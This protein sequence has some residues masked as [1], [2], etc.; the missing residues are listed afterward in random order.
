[1]KK[2]IIEYLSVSNEK[3]IL[4]FIERMISETKNEKVLD[5]YY[6]IKKEMEKGYADKTP[7]EIWI[8]EGMGG[9]IFPL[10]MF[11][12]HN[13]FYYQVRHWITSQ[14]DDHDFLRVVVPMFILENNYKKSQK[15]KFHHPS[16]EYKSFLNKRKEYIKRIENY[17]I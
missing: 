13:V 4:Y 17:D 10:D 11:D 15:S 1:M 2:E 12:L 7:Q 3:L 9:E 5:V 8:E 16:L 14:C 6:K